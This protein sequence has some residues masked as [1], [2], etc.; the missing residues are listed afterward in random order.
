METYSITQYPPQ[1]GDT[2]FRT[3]NLDIK[4][5]NVGL[6]KAFV[7]RSAI[8]FFVEMWGVTM[9]PS[10]TASFTWWQSA[11]ICFVR[12]WKT[13]FAA[14][15]IAAWLS[16]WRVIRREWLEPSVFSNAFSHLSSRRVYAIALYSASLFL[17]SLSSTKLENSPSRQ[18]MLTVSDVFLDKLPNLSRTKLWCWDR[19]LTEGWFLALVNL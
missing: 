5:S 7:K 3:P 6:G 1:V 8:W 17:V 11:S 13:G 10:C 2:K 14:I 18:C 4:Y 16:Q 9:R 15:W 19:C 12:S